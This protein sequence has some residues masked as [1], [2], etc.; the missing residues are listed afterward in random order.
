MTGPRRYGSR[1]PATYPTAPQL[2]A[3]RLGPPRSPHHP[4]SRASPLLTGDARDLAAYLPI[5]TARAALGA[6]SAPRAKAAAPSEAG[7]QETGS[8]LREPSQAGDGKW[9]DYTARA[10]K[11]VA[12]NRLGNAGKV[13]A[14]TVIFQSDFKNRN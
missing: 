2:M 1:C 5:R 14:N 11:P 6:P 7:M 13:T 10:T 8:A 9:T 4:W 12:W 3:P